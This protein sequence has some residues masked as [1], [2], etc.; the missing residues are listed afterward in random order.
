VELLQDDSGPLVQPGRSERFDDFGTGGGWHRQVV[1]ALD[2]AADGALRVF[3]RYLCNKYGLP[4]YHDGWMEVTRS[5]EWLIEH[6]TRPTRES[7]TRLSETSSAVPGAV[8]DLVV[9]AIPDRHPAVDV[10]G[11]AALAGDPYS[12]LDRDPAHQ[13]GVRVVPAAAACLPTATTWRCRPMGS[14]ARSNFL[15]VLLLV[16]GGA[17]PGRAA[18]RGAARLREDAHLREPRRAVLGG[19]RA[20]GRAARQL[21]PRPLRIL[22]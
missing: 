20:D 2:V 8:N 7:K 16:G 5:L 9:D 22:R 15:A 19:D 12:A 4:V 11:Q 18:R 6:W 3:D 21:P 10:G 14:P 13:P 1:Q 17:R